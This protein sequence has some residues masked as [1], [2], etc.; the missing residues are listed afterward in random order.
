MVPIDQSLRRGWS[1]SA[2]RAQTRHSARDGRV[3]RRRGWSDIRNRAQ[4]LGCRARSTTDH[5]A[6]M[7]LLSNRF[8]TASRTPAP[9]K[10]TEPRPTHSGF[11]PQPR[12]RIP[13]ISSS[14]GTRCHRTYREAC[15]S[16]SF[17]AVECRH[18]HAVKQDGPRADAHLSGRPERPLI[19]L[20]RAAQARRGN[21]WR[22][23]ARRERRR[24][25]ARAVVGFGFVI[26]GPPHRRSAPPIQ[27]RPSS[28]TERSSAA[29][30]KTGQ[31]SRN[32]SDRPAEVVT[33][34]DNEPPDRL[35]IEQTTGH[36]C[37]RGRA[38]VSGQR[39]RRRHNAPDSPHNRT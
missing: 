34:R 36:L 20:S 24:F 32:L 14:P 9:K 21:W 39:R 16:P 2:C 25:A 37:T 35:E 5:T 28:I 17:H 19:R 13:P 10:V 23:V 6:R 18:Q 38:S 15:R 29:T 1:S 27:S 12:S 30:S 26:G 3:E 4:A 11:I 7:M 31:D 8:R 22:Q 33:I